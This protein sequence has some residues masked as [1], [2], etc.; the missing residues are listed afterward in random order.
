MIRKYSHIIETLLFAGFVLLAGYMSGNPA[1]IGVQFHPFYF[2]IL[3]IG[4]RYGY[5][6][7]LLSALILGVVYLLFDA[8]DATGIADFRA[9]S[10]QPLAFVAFAMFIGLLV[11][12]DKKD[13]S[14]LKENIGNLNDALQKKQQ[15]IGEVM[16]LN[17][18][19]SE[20]LTI[21]DKTFNVVF[22]ETRGFYS[23]D[24][25][26]L[27]EAAFGVLM[28]V[29]NAPGAFVFYL[30]GTELKL[31]CPAD[32]GE[33][34]QIFMEKNSARLDE[35]IK[36]HE[37][38]RLNHQADHEPGARV[39]VIMGP[40]LH[41]ESNTLYGVAVIEDLDFL[42]YNENTWLTFR[43]LCFWLGNVFHFRAATPESVRVM[44]AE[45]DSEFD[46]LIGYGASRES[47]R[48]M[49]ERMLVDEDSAMLP[50]EGPV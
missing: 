1:Y 17:A 23:E 26:H 29:I 15:E 3:L 32:A 33:D 44:P 41:H 4:S 12:V 39:P 43:N 35:V 30:D 16:S 2:V 14:S 10:F 9:A 5:L 28:R 11:E 13:I 8:S 45:I 19:L 18:S 20:Q 49:V 40:I 46:Y 38:V 31:A 34:S 48:L 22:R 27:Y 47:V 7:C 25:N 50:G 36:Q 37:F 42:T 6:R 21:S 24:I